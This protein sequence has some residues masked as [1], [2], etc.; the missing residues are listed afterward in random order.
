MLGI[1]YIFME[2]SQN[3]EINMLYKGRL[4]LFYT[5]FATMALVGF[6]CWLIIRNRSSPGKTHKCIKYHLSVNSIS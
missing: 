5:V 2:K 3:Y 1:T 6:F 4:F